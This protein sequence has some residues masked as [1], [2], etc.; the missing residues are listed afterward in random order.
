MIKKHIFSNIY[1]KKLATKAKFNV[2]L[3]F[4]I[5]FFTII[6]LFLL[7]DSQI[8]KLPDS[9]NLLTEC[10]EDADIDCSEILDIYLYE[11][12][13]KVI[14]RERKLQAVAMQL[15]FMSPD[16]DALECEP[17]Y[18]YYSALWWNNAPL[19][20]TF[21]KKSLPTYDVTLNCSELTQFIS[22]ELKNRIREKEKE[23]RAMGKLLDE[24]EER[25]REEFGYEYLHDYKD[26]H[27]GEYKLY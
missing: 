4:L 11:T 1:N 7:I 20:G 17:K 16:A 24:I 10:I 8:T 13:E 12:V 19:L 14:D 21:F 5:A 9:D 22:E 6:V 26:E 23:L 27:K 15:S 2:F 18:K 25:N 3:L